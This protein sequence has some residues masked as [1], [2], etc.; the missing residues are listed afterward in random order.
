MIIYEDLLKQYNRATGANC[1]DVYDK[2]FREWLVQYSCDLNAY[3]D[4]LESRGYSFKDSNIAE[5]DKG[6]F[7]SI[8]VRTGASN[9]KERLITENASALHIS[10]RRVK[11]AKKEIKILHNG[12]LFSID[13]YDSFMSYNLSSRNQL[14]RFSMIHNLGKDILYGVFGN[15]NDLDKKYKLEGVQSIYNNMN[16]GEFEICYHDSE[17]TYFYMVSSK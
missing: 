7:D 13:D 10:K 8:L 12:Q 5:L 16:N 17:D 11:I 15:K 4:F 2:H 6:P 9:L 14:D 3:I 1:K